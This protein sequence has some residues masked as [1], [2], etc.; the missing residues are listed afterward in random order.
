MKKP[1][2]LSGGGPFFDD[3]IYQKTYKGHSTEGSP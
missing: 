1:T 2:T 3:T